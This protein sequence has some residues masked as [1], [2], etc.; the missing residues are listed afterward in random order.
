MTRTPVSRLAAALII[1]I[2]LAGV[3]FSGVLAR[4]DD[5]QTATS[6]TARFHSV[7]QAIAAGYALPPEGP[8][9]ECV[10]SSSGAMGYHYIN[11]AL[12]S[13]DEAAVADPARPEALVYAPDKH[14]K[15]RL[16]AV[17]YVIFQADMPQQ[18]SLFGEDFMDMTVNPFGLPPFWALHAWVWR[19]NPDGTFEPFNRAVSCPST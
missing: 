15:L 7:E 4:R 5:L 19:D 13:G 2:S 17:E 18:P 16:V 11:G 9:H 10:A 14:G 12:L 8:L 6:A 3:T 1:A